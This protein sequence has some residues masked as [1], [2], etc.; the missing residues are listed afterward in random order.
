MTPATLELLAVYFGTLVT[1]VSLHSADPGTTGTS[2]ITAAGRQ[3]VTWT[4]GSSDGI[5]TA[6][7]V[8]FTIPASTAGLYLGFWSASSGGTF[9]AKALA[10]IPSGASRVVQVDPSVSI[11]SI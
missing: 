11:T 4:G 5:A 10:S 9:R 2:E 7:T 1:H 8:S 3:A 6:A